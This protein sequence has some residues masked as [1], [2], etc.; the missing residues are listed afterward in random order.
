[1]PPRDL[2]VGVNLLW[3]LPGGVG[4]SEEYL[5][6]QLTGLRDVAPEIRAR[7]SC[8]P[9]SPPPT[10]SWPPAT[11]WSSPPST[12]GA[13]AGGSSPRRRGCRAAS[14]T[15]TSSTTAAAPCRCARRARSLLTLHDVQ[16]RSYPEY[17][18]PVK[19]R[20]LRLAM[21]R[22]VRR[23]DVVAVPSEYV[24]GT[25]IDAF[26]RDPDRVVV[27]PHGVDV[28]TDRDRRRRAPAALRHRRPA[29]RRLPGAHPPAQEPPLPARPAGR[30]VERPRPG[31]RPARRARPRRG[32][33]RGGDRAARPRRRVVRPGTG[34]RRRPRRAD[35]RRRGARVP[36]R[37]R[38]LRGARARGDGARHAGACAATGPRCPRSPAT[39]RSC[40]RSISTPGRARSTRSP[41]RRDELV[42]A[43]R[44]A[45]DAVHDAGV[46][47][48]PRRAHTAAC[49]AT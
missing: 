26:G 44:R 41:R 19:R 34:V 1:M 16:Y 9:A 4:G 23:A 12:P 14:A 28:P 40:C 39:P 31:A 2:A 21:P 45:G 13:A 36:V 29:L 15:S 6:R 33:R 35:R 8:C 24:R 43:G 5:V 47:G 32:R 18:T 38:G 22:S 42:A 37:V 46:R 48:P 25:V 27:V 10:P 17:L 20:Y 30:A 49:A 3:C 11:S 7:C